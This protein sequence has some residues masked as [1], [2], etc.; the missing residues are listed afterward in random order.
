M[1]Q[2]P[3]WEIGRQHSLNWVREHQWRGLKTRLWHLLLP[4]DA[5]PPPGNDEWAW[6]TPWTHVA[7]PTWD[8]SDVSWAPVSIFPLLYTKY[9]L[10]R[11]LHH[12]IS[13]KDENIVQK[14]RILFVGIPGILGIFWRISIF[15][16]FPEFFEKFLEFWDSLGVS[17]GMRSTAKCWYS[18]WKAPHWL[19]QWPSSYMKFNNHFVTLTFSHRFSKFSL[20]IRISGLMMRTLYFPASIS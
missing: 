12:H 4:G 18:F 9:T 13:P 3:R 11:L 1:C 15:L 7:T 14:F 16:E 8:M 5:T 20:V 6:D 2:S 19:M 17:G 10:Y